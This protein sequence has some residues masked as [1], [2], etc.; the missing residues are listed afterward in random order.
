MY[1]LQIQEP[2]FTTRESYKLADYIDI[3]H[4]L[5][6]P[7]TLFISKS[8]YEDSEAQVIH[9]FSY[10]I[11][12][13]RVITWSAYLRKENRVVFDG[14]CK[15]DSYA[16]IGY[17]KNWQKRGFVPISAQVENRYTKRINKYL[18]RDSHP[19]IKSR[20][21]YKALLLYESWYENKI[22]DLEFTKLFASLKQEDLLYDYR[23][24]GRVDHDLDNILMA[25]FEVVNGREY[26]YGSDAEIFSYIDDIYKQVGSNL[27]VYE[28]ELN[29]NQMIGDYRYQKE[30]S[31]IGQAFE[32]A[33][34]RSK[35]SSENVMELLEECPEIDEDCWG[36][37]HDEK[38]SCS[39][40]TYGESSF[41]ES[42]YRHPDRDLR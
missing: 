28:S 10:S 33:I 6:S 32:Y 27:F 4:A 37:L 39:I 9:M 8:D 29:V 36:E 21:D 12:K 15:Y 31:L 24:T 34:S 18:E 40:Y 5:S 35:F 16:F 2:K 38:S 13:E 17:Q 19:L 20:E 42:D 11:G 7:V 30:A 41:N 14:G 1:Q 22:T 3:S 23:S 25:F 26:E